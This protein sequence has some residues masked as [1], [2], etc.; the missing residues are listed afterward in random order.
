[1][2]SLEAQNLPAR[3]SAATA[4]QILAVR[5]TRVWRKIVDANPQ[6]VHRLA[7]ETRHH[8]VTLELFKLLDVARCAAQGEGRQKS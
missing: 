4:R 2:T 3:V 1:M 6:L 7:G 5:S 8:Y